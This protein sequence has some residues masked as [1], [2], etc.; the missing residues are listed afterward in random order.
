MSSLVYSNHARTR[1]Q[2]RG[3]R[4]RDVELIVDLIVDLGTRVSEDAYILRRQD[5]DREIEL[6]RREIQALSRLRG[7]KVVVAA[8]TVVT[9]YHPRPA[10]R[11]RALRRG[12]ENAWL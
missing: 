2:Q 11:K 1:M 10:V 3:L 8:D 4:E 7:R 12:R 5:I 6:R 9:G